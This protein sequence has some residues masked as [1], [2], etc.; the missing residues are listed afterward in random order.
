MKKAGIKSGSNRKKG[1]KRKAATEELEEAAVT[2]DGAMESRVQPPKVAAFPL[3][4][5]ISGLRTNSGDA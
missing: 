3:G 2:E 1:L 5:S 4:F